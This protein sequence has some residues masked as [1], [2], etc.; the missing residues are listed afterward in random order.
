MMMESRWRGEPTTYLS[1]SAEWL[2]ERLLWTSLGMAM[3]WKKEK[4]GGGYWLD[5]WW[6]EWKLKEREAAGG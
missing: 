4:C 6:V 1:S 2:N 5:G 3:K